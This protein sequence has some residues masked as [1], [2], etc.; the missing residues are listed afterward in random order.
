MLNDYKNYLVHCGMS[1]R[2]NGRP[3]SIYDYMRGIKFV[4]AHEGLTIEQLAENISSICPLYQ[5]GSSKEI[6]GKKI[7][8]SVRCSLRKFLQWRLETQVAA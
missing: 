8:R 3:S 4:L 2:V 1:L 5:A 7:S 6:L